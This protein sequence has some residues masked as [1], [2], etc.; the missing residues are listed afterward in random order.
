MGV[1]VAVFDVSGRVVAVLA[2]GRLEAGEHARVWDGRNLEGRPV[3]PGVYLV[4]MNAG[5][6]SA[7]RKAVV[8]K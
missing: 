4:R 7:T 3:S 5:D 2:D 8:L 1:E 6:F